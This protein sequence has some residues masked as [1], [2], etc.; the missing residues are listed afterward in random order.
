LHERHGEAM[1]LAMM[2]RVWATVN[3]V[4]HAKLA[5]EWQCSAST[6][7]RFLRNEQSPD[8][9]T[10]GRII[11][12]C[13][14]EQPAQVLVDAKELERRVDRLERLYEGDREAINAASMFIPLDGHP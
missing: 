4:E 2:I 9:P 10:I 12:W 11:A 14:G 13:F 1:K 5:E 3:G 6:V 7:T 8:G